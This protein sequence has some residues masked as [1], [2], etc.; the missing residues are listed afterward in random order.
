MADEEKPSAHNGG[1][2]FPLFFALLQP[3]G[4]FAVTGSRPSVAMWI[5]TVALSTIIARSIRSF[6]RCK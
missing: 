1:W 5:G 6:I 2:K 3:I 4:Y